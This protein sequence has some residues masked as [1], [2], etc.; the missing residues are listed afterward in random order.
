MSTAKTGSCVKAA[1]WYAKHLGWRVFPVGKDKR[2]LTQHGCNEAT[3]DLEQIARWWHRWPS[4]G[5]ALATGD[6]SGCWVLDVDPQHDGEASFLELVAKHGQLPD[7]VTSLTGG[8]G[9]HYL[10]R[11]PPPVGGQPQIVQNQQGPK[12]RPGRLPPGIDSRG[13]GGYIVLPPSVH[14]S[15]RQYAWE[16][17]GRPDEVAVAEAP[18]WLLALVLARPDAYT[19]YAAD[20]P[21]ERFP[22]T[23][24]GQRRLAE[25]VESVRGAIRGH[26]AHA[27]CF[28]AGKRA[29]RLI[30]GRCVDAATAR[31][32]LAAA[33]AGNGLINR[34]DAVKASEDGMR[35]GLGKP[36]QP[37]RRNGPPPPT[38][39]DFYGE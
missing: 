6:A 4:S 10:F 26:G 39:A 20:L 17:S 25:A 31:A 3:T 22:A 34:E 35:I 24:E 23:P 37:P 33:I 36:W 21:A 8:G 5:V 32:A 30:G 28:E 18:D 1:A 19:G 29:G 7:T 9:Q 16:A 2:P 12:R 13:R 27:A 14:P 11:W 38:D 15:G